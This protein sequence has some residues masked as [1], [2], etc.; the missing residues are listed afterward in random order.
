MII[1]S[2]LERG[3]KMYK[4]DD[5]LV[6]TAQEVVNYMNDEIEESYFDKEMTELYGD[7]EI[8]GSNYVAIEVLKQIDETTYSCEFND[9]KDSRTKDA[10]RDII[11]MS[12][13][14]ILTIYGIEIEYSET[15]VLRNNR[16][17]EVAFTDLEEAREFCIDTTTRTTVSGST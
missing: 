4:V 13:G 8:C 9:W 15:E 10:Y 1:I 17:D 12:D 5:R 11:R 2:C 16:D 6:E 7:V 3:F 14:D